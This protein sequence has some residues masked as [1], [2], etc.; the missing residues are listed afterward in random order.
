MSDERDRAT[1]DRQGDDATQ[2]MPADEPTSTFDPFADDDKDP[3]AT[4]AMPAG[5]EATQKVT[6][7][8]WS[9]R[10]SVPVHDFEPVP[11][12]A[13][14][15]WQEE[16]ADRSWLRPVVIALVVLI[17][18]GMLGAGL[19]LIF[20]RLGGR[21]APAPVITATTSG[22]PTPTGIPS[23][24][25]APTAPA[26]TAVAQ[27]PVPDVV[28]QSEAAAKQQLAAMGLS[29]TVSR[30]AASGVNPGTVTATQPGA[31]AMVP[32]G[33][34]VT[35]IV[36]ATPAPTRSALPAPSRSVA[37]TTSTTP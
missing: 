37:P 10:A 20:S 28:G 25:E 13:A 34:Q 18:L 15:Q 29:F 8:V 9:A 2:R 31:G 3:G 27:V 26:T 21:S 4:R 11:G 33:A 22:V 30:R 24:T 6:P 5:D 16:N 12:P 23:A 35:L 32:R 36:A 17:L 14:A 1:E 19:W 7:Q